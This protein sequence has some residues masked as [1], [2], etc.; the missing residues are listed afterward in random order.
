[1]AYFSTNTTTLPLQG[2]ET[3]TSIAQH[4]EKGFV[5][6]RLGDGV[7]QQTRSVRI[8]LKNFSL[9][10]EN[11]RILRKTEG[12]SL[13][14]QPLPLSTYDWHIGKYAQDF[15][16]RKFGHTNHTAT[17]QAHTTHDH[18]HTAPHHIMSA[19]KVKEMLTSTTSHWNTLL[20]FTSEAAQP[21]GWC[22]AYT[23]PSLLHYAYPFY[24]DPLNPAYRDRGLGMMIRAI[25]WAQEQ[26]YEYVYIG[27]LTRPHDIYKL[28]FAGLEWFDPL[29]TKT[30]SNNIEEAKNILKEI[31]KDIKV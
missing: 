18:P 26:K 12:L 28:Q 2:P 5:F 8:A 13:A 21:E 6:T 1:M 25:L 14:A 29:T 24:T 20:T 16:D 31:S 22:I 3:L 19:V 23:Q 15:Y 9:S 17:V 10:S 4:Y 7:L 11:R 27:S 30:W